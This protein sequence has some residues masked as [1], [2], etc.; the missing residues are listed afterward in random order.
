MAKSRTATDWTDVLAAVPLFRDLPRRH[1]ARLTKVAKIERLPAYTRIVRA[2][3]RGDS[4]CLLLEGSATV[5][6]SGRR[7]VSIGPG[8]FF[9]ELS[10]LDGGPRSA[11]VE[12]QEDVLLA[13][14]GRKDFLRMVES[15]PQVAVA[16][17]ETMASR[18]RGLERATAAH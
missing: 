13:R 7:A 10:L 6:A 8:D 15:E 9:G 5:K 12:A 16:L 4:F 14:I 2:G 3:Q 18:L 1:V 17:L 11:T